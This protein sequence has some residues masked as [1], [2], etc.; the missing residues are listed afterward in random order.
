MDEVFKALADRNRRKMLDMVR[1]NPGM[2]VNELAEHFEFSRYAVMKH[3]K[4]LE[5]AKLLLPKREWKEKKLY[6]NAIPIREIHDRWISKYSGEWASR[7]TK[8]KNDLEKE[9]E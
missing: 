8:L 3:L 9:K 1:D 7:L 4:I 5:A 2:N 6:L